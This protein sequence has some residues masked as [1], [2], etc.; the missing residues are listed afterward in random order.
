MI[1]VEVTTDILDP[2]KVVYTCPE[3][4]MVVRLQDALDAGR[5]LVGIIGHAQM[6]AA[7]RAMIA[8]LFGE[9]PPGETTGG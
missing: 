5:A 4:G 3:C 8:E 9:P 7:D 6:H 2:Y 1:P